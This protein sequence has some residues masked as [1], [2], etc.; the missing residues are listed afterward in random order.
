MQPERQFTHGE[1]V[2]HVK[3]EAEESAALIEPVAQGVAADVEALGG[4]ERLAVAAQICAEGGD[5]LG[6][7][8]LVV[9]D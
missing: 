3:V 6:V 5:Q 4:A 7:E 1:R 2:E 9:V 8:S